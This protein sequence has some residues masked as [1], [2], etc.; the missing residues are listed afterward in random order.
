MMPKKGTCD[1]EACVRFWEACE[2]HRHGKKSV[3]MENDH[4]IAEGW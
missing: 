1:C 3:I 4:S 2:A